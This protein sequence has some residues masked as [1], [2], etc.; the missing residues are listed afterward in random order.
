MDAAEILLDA[1][2]ARGAVPITACRA[3]AVDAVLGALPLR[4]AG[5]AKANNFKA[6]SGRALACPDGQGGIEQVLFGLGSDEPGDPFL[7]GKLARL[8][9][10]GNYRFAGGVEDERLAALGWLLE[11]YDFARYRAAARSP[12]SLAV[13]E[14]VDAAALRSTA[15]AVALVRD[16]VNTPANDFGPAELE[17]A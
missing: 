1:D 3:S 2:A 8:L 11:G 5:W 4:Q 14:G 15:M 6:E 7:P 17:A 12:G 16:L 9:P 10:Q 13:P